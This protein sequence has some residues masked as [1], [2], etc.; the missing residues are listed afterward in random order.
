MPEPL[1]TTRTWLETLDPKIV[2]AG[3]VIALCL[4]VWIGFKVAGGTVTGPDHAPCA[5]CAER[6]LEAD[7]LGAETP[8]P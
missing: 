5:D 2:A 3:C 8:E 1:D 6:R 7:I 4:G